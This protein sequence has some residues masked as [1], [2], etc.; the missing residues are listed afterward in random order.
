MI[1]RKLEVATDE[2]TVSGR[3]FSPEHDGC[4]SLVVFYMD[5]FGLRPA[6]TEMAARLVDAGYAVLQPDLY[7]RREPY[8]PFDPGSTF[9]DPEERERIMSLIQSVRI[10]DV[11][12]DTL[13]L[14]DALENPTG[15]EQGGE[16]G[17]GQLAGGEPILGTDRW[18][19]VGYC[20]G[21]RV[22][23]RIAEELP[24]RVRAAASIHG[25]GLVSDEADSPHRKVSDIRGTLYIGVADEDRSCTPEDQRVLREALEEAGIEFRMELY[26]GARHGFAVPDLPVHD[27]EAAER[28]WSRVLSLFDASLRNGTRSDP[29]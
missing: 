27:P 20:M 5:A 14:V 13:L 11:V 18:G 8:D 17:S 24:S 15:G 6:L 16:E 28:H 9:N 2:G 1:E 22:A 21:G 7:W 3:F 29:A 25:G 10:D 19:C 26:E 12:R 4:G 23:F